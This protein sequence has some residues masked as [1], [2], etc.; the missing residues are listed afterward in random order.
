VFFATQEKTFKKFQ[1]FKKL[2]HSTKP[3]K[4]VTTMPVKRTEDNGLINDS[5]YAS[6]HHHLTLQS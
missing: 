2:K 1:R 5:K 3:T 6:S 4:K